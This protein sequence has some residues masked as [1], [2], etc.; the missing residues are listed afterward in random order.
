M[1]GEINE[2]PC[3]IMISLKFKYFKVNNNIISQSMQLYA[4]TRIVDPLK[5]HFT[6]LL[7]FAQS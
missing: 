5:C 2:I 1:H 3:R 7:I 4:Y 6:Y